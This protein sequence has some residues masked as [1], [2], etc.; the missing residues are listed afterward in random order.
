[1]KTQIQKSAITQTLVSTAI[2]LSVTLSPVAQAGFFGDLVGVVTAPVKFVGKHLGMG[3][4]GG[5]YV[6][7]GG[8]SEPFTG[9]PFIKA[10]PGMLPSGNVGKASPKQYTK[11]PTPKVNPGMLNGGRSS[12]VFRPIVT[13]SKKVSQP[14]TTPVQKTSVNNS[15]VSKPVLTPTKKVSKSDE[16]K[17]RK[18]EKRASEK[19][20]RQAKK[21][22]K[23]E[24]RAKKLAKKEKRA[25][26]K[27]R[28]QAE[29]LAKNAKRAK[30]S[31]N[32][33]HKR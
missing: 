26:A 9:A 8:D 12:L 20:H 25:N 19:K 2:A 21:L 18:A 27:K 1:M 32:K 17:L 15:L 13:P 33:R 29:K 22:A 23:K 3:G 7:R 24:K 11:Q 16:K 4:N 14:F 31:N 30:R 5:G 6:G 10:T 28:R